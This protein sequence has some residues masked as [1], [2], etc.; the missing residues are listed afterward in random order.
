MSGFLT[1]T[2]ITAAGLWLA[3]WLVSGIEIAGLGTL[4]FAAVLLGLVNGLIRPIVVVLTFPITLV[5][6]GLFLWVINAAMLGFVAWLL[7]GFSI[8]GFGS[9]L[10]GALIVG[11]TSWL[12]SW[13]IGP[14]GRFELLVT[15]RRRHG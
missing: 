3:A 14:S 7:A 9:G 15:E 5:T 4:A 13:H 1:R 10:L 2:A 8:A 12:A 6:L 11:I